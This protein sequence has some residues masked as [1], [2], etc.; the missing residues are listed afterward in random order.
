MI[1]TGGTTGTAGAGGTSSA[2]NCIDAIKLNNY[3]AT[4]A[5]P[6]SMCKNNQTDESARCEAMIDCEDTGYPCSGNCP[7]D[8]LNTAMGDGVVKDCVS[9]LVTASC[10]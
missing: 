5:P 7:T 4:G 1:G 2:K 9:A 6:C 10:G 8:C 3:S